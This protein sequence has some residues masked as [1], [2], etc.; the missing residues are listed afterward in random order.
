[1]RQKGLTRYIAVCLLSGYFWLGVSGLAA[2]FYGSQSAGPIYD[3]MLHSVFVGF[4]IG[5]VFGHAPII[6]P[7]VLGLA[8]RYQ[9]IFYFPLVLLQ[10]S[11][12]LRVVGN[13]A[14]VLWLRQ[15]GGLL[16]AIAILAFLPLVAPIWRER[17]P[18]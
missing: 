9:P 14:A 7:A 12:L 2:I 8:I 1:V 17:D 10:I 11:L 5:M 16:N 18:H 13:L 15:W 4:V 6:F 3:L